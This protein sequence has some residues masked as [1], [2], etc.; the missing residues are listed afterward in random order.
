MTMLMQVSA[1]QFNSVQFNSIQMTSSK[2]MHSVRTGT[3]QTTRKPHNKPQTLQ[4]SHIIHVS[5]KKSFGNVLEI[6]LT[7]SNA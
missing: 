1:I 6:T 5:W 7:N 4:V 2:P 3:A